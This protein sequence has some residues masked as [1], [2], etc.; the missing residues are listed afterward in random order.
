MQFVASLVDG[1]NSKDMNVDG[2]STPVTFQYAP[3]AALTE[4]VSLTCILVNA[5]SSALNGFTSALANGI[6]VNQTVNGVTSEVKLIKDKSD[7][8]S[9][10]SSDLV[11][12]LSSSSFIGTFKAS[13]DSP[14]ILSNGDSIAVTIQDDLTAISTLVMSIVVVQN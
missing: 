8:V 2:S 3:T 6:V 4:V 5:G 12:P 9:V 7:L 11:E 13:V 10:F 14:L 1:S